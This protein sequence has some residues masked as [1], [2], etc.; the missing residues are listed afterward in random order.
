MTGLI[1][2][3]KMASAL[4][5]DADAAAWETV[6]GYYAGPFFK[7]W[8]EAGEAWGNLE[9]GINTQ[10]AVLAPEPYYNDSWAQ[11]FVTWA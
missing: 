10:N 9:G 2:L 1:S 5:K 4:G 3:A 7:A 8:G 11:A 6:L